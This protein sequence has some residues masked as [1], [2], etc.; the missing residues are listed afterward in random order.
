MEDSTNN[1]IKADRT[2]FRPQ[3]Y[4]NITIFGFGLAAL[5]NS[6]HIII[7]PLLVLDL[8]PAAQKSTFLAMITFAGLIVGMGIQPVAGMVSDRSNLRWGRRKPYI[9]AG[10]ILSI[11]LLFCAGYADTY[12]A[13]LIIWCL[14]QASSNIAQGPFQAFIPDLVPDRRRGLASGVKV[15]MEIV[16]GIALLRIIGSFMDRRLTGDSEYW[17]LVAL[18]TLAGVLLATMLVT[19]FTIKERPASRIENH[20]APLSSLY[21]SFRIDVRKNRPFIYFLASRMFFIMALTTVQTFGLFFFTDV[22][23]SEKPFASAA[24]IF[25]IIGVSMLAAV[26]PAGRLS[27]RLGRRPVLFFS[28]V[29]GAA[30]MLVLLFLPEY[31]LMVA[32]GCVI[33]VAAGA[34]M[35]TSWALATD[36]VEQGQSARYLGLAN[37]AMAGGAALSRAIGPGIDYFNSRMAGM[38][39]SFML[40]VCFLYIVVSTL[41]LLKVKKAN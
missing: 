36:L 6:F 9:V 26:Y 3:D 4:I 10:S 29:L 25:V 2:G 5:S 18:G 12:V 32:G 39:Y 41:F 21:T 30:G 13:I 22:V 16:G 34:F 14:L 27:D 40:L 35:S 11:I 28:G 37:M 15:L 19:T 20:P 17:L 23:L 24:N 31:W 7:L 38:G 8:V 1:I 33:G